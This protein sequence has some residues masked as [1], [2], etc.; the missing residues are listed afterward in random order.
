M[1]CETCDHTMHNIGLT[2]LNAPA[3]WCPRCGT[4]KRGHD[5]DVPRLV[6]RARTF[7]DTVREHLPDADARMVVDHWAHVTG[8]NESTSPESERN[9]HARPAETQ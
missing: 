7:R 8:L 4:L 5:L 1:S 9:Q 6:V 2:Y 3:Y